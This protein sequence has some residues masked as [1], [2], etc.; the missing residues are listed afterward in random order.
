MNDDTTSLLF[1]IPFFTDEFFFKEFQ[2]TMKEQRRANRFAFVGI[3][4]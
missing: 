2:M 3:V 4:S 1:W